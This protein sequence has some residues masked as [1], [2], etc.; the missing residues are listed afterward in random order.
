MLY[1]NSVKRKNFKFIL[2]FFFFC[3]TLLKN[4]AIIWMFIA[5]PSD[6]IAISNAVAERSERKNVQ[7]FHSVSLQRTFSAGDY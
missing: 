1:L 7:R 6:N 4:R 3:F 5:Q 2:S